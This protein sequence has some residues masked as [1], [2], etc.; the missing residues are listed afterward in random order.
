[1]TLRRKIAI[2][3]VSVYL[4]LSLLTGSVVPFWFWP[5][6]FPVS[7]LAAETNRWF[8]RGIVPDDVIMVCPILT[9]GLLW[10][11]GIGL[12]KLTERLMAGK[13]NRG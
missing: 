7:V 9:L 2:G 1:V 6:S 11:V 12:G 8:N 10:L 4:A 5:T 3:T 13:P